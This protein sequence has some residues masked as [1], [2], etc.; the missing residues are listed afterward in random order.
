MPYRRVFLACGLAC[1]VGCAAEAG[2]PRNLPP[3]EQSTIVGPDD[4]VAAGVVMLV[5]APLIEVFSDCGTL[6][7]S[8]SAL[9]PDAAVSALPREV[10]FESLLVAE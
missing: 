8:S 4:P 7:L 5:R 2:P 6:E 1:L 10:L 3:P 9:L